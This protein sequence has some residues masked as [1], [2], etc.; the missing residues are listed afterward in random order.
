M[1]N[2]T[3]GSKKPAF[4][5]SNDV[6]I[7]YS[8]RPT[9]ST[10]DTSSNVFK[11]IDS[12]ILYTVEATSADGNLNLGTLPGV[13]NLR[14]PLDIFGRVGFYTVYIKPKE[15]K[16]SIIDVS[17]LAA[18]PNVRGI[19]LNTNS[20][21]E[22]GSIGNNGELIGYRIEYF[23]TTDPTKRLDTYRLITSNNKCAPITQN[24]ND[25]LSTDIK[26]SFNDSSNLTFCTVT[27]SSSLSFNSGSYPFIGEKGQI[28]ALINTKF[29]PIM[30]DIE[31]TE[32][33][34]ETISTMLEGDQLRNLDA[35]IITTFNSDGG[36]Y[37]QACY[38]EVVDSEKNTHHDYKIQTTTTTDEA[39]KLEEIKEN[40]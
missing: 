16:T 37:H 28:I 30:L 13:Y 26:Y 19:V 15:I 14:L 5:T 1:A 27:P 11:Q 10:E 21:D 40:L 2:G 23:D 38:G 6:D 20:F 33:S 39:A 29:N 35:A 7:F 3:Y 32:H 22:D 31:I 4:I 36:V 34:I 17:T 12:D 8:Y 9:R 25:S 18:Y 24:L